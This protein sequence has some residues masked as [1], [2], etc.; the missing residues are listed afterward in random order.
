MLLFFYVAFA[1]HAGVSAP[2]F[3]SSS[4]IKLQFE[5]PFAQLLSEVDRND[6]EGTKKKKALGVLR[7]GAQSLNVTLN[8]RGNS[9]LLHCSF[10]KLGLE[11]NKAEAQSTPFEGLTNAALGTHCMTPEEFAAKKDWTRVYAEGLQFPYREAV[12]YRW[13]EI[14]GLATYH[15][16]PALIT[17]VDTSIQSPLPASTFPAI[18]IEPSSAFRRRVNGSAVEWKSIEEALPFLEQATLVR[19]ILFEA[20]IGNIDWSLSK[21]KLPW[22]LE[23]LKLPSGRWHLIPEDFSLATVALGWKPETIP[24]TR[25]DF[26]YFASAPKTL[27]DEA[28]RDFAKN[29]RKLVEALEIL[30]DDPVGKQIMLETIETKFDE[31]ARTLERSR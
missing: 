12:V 20:L 9:T 31:F 2:L 4:P 27:Q 28:V 1:A 18:L 14:L 25:E 15:V 11:W 23:V 24:W 10:P 30:G 16:R 26:K 29:K 17:Y 19:V 7:F 5:A 13:A 3:Q 6:P 22:N 8:Y 21:N